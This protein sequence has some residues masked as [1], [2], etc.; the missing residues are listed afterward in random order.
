VLAALVMLLIDGDQIGKL[1]QGQ[2]LAG[3]GNRELLEVRVA[4]ISIKPYEFR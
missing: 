1:G 2:P 3:I 4:C